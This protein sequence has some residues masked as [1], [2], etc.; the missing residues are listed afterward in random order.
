[1]IQVKGHGGRRY[2]V[3]CIHARVGVF[4]HDLTRTDFDPATH[5]RTVAKLISCDDPMTEIPEA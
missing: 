2:Q 1:M 5:L 3:A 4:E